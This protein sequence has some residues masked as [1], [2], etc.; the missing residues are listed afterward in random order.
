MGKQEANT[1]Q[2]KL[3]SADAVPKLSDLIKEKLG[4]NNHLKLGD[5]EVV[6][7]GFSFFNKAENRPQSVTIPAGTTPDSVLTGL[8]ANGHFNID[9]A[10]EVRLALPGEH[11]PRTL[12]LSTFHTKAAFGAAPALR[13]GDMVQVYAIKTKAGYGIAYQPLKKG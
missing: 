8:F 2:D 10:Y 12:T 3:E 7:V 1:V 6:S 5:G 11:A 4:K 13:S 9:S